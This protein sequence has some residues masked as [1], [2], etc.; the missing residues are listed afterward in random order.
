[1]AHLDHVVAEVQRLQFG[2]RAAAAEPID[3][4]HRERRPQLV[5]PAAEYRAR[6]Q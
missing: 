3:D 4:Q 6:Q 1:V 5:L 2:E